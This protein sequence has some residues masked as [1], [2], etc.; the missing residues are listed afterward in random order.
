[1]NTKD[2]GE[3]DVGDLIIY[4]RL[5]RFSANGS[6]QVGFWFLQDPTFGLTNT[7]SGGGFKFSGVHQDNDVLVQSNFSQ[8]G[9]ID[10]ITVYKW[11]ARGLVQVLSAADCVGPPPSPADDAACGTVNRAPRPLHGLTRRRRTRAPRARS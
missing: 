9:V 10:R 3:N 6:A 11:Q 8:G 4:Y 7:P 1:V 2:T 5:D